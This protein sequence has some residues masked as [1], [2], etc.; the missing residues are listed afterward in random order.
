ME[1]VTLLPNSILSLS[2]ETADRLLALGDADA[3]LVYLH[4]LRRGSVQGLNWPAPRLQAAMDR[5]AG[6][7]LTGK[8]QVQ[9]NKPAPE[10]EVQA[11]EYTL[12]DITAALGAGSNF[13]SLADEIERRLGKRLSTADLKTLYTLYDHLAMPAEV[14]LLVTGWC[15][16]EVERKYGAGRKPF[17]S[18][19]RREA[20]RWAREGI[21]TAPRAEEYLQQLMSRRTREGEIIRLL[22]LPRRPL[23]ER[24]QKDVAGWLDMGFDNDALRLAYEKTVMGTA[25]K[26]MDWR[27]MN[28]ILLRWHEAGLHTAAQIQSGDGV[29]KQ[30]GQNRKSPVS[31]AQGPD[32]QAREDMEYIRRLM[33]Q[34]T[35]EQGG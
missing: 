4:L 9:L 30:T 11:P 17:L 24:G 21:D 3:A 31:P 6:C 35:P 12:D 27:Y 13:S 20:F 5:L 16:L 25:A 32:R 10:P 22:D 2:G 29:P 23:V 14:I 1:P 26:S 28:K 18:Q 33:Q 34:V 8:T 19:I 7:G 15:E